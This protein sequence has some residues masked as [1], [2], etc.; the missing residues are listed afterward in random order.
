MPTCNTYSKLPEVL[1]PS[2]WPCAARPAIQW[3]SL[4]PMLHESH[5]SLLVQSQGKVP[6][7]LASR[8]LRLRPL[9][10]HSFIHRHALPR[11]IS[12]SRSRLVTRHVT[13]P[14]HAAQHSTTQ[15]GLPLLVSG[16]G[17]P[18]SWFASP[19]FVYRNWFRRSVSRFLS[20]LSMELH[21]RSHPLSKHVCPVPLLETRARSCPSQPQQ[22]LPSQLVTSPGCPGKDPMSPGFSRASPC[23]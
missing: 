7:P 11:Y 2:W 13:A 6:C 21:G 14:R 17:C 5:D 19:I 16:P 9:S 1:N 12:R 10:R 18:L 22:Q 15:P 3:R 23:A 8:W 20:L 4:S